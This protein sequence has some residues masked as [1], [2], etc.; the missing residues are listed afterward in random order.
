MSKLIRIGYLHLEELEPNEL[1]EIFNNN[2]YPHFIGQQVLKNKN[3]PLE[4]LLKN[5]NIQCIVAGTSVPKQVYDKVLDEGNLSI[6]TYALRLSHTPVWF[7][8]RAFELF[9]NDTDVRFD[10]SRNDNTPLRVLE[11]LVISES[12][13]IRSNIVRNKNTSDELLEILQKDSEPRV[14]ISIME[15]LKKRGE[16]PQDTIWKDIPNIKIK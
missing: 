9:S 10:L 16:I 12:W 4:L 5:T 15:L 3:T 1:L 11:K 2:P 13:D 14:L 7:L 8:E 6:I